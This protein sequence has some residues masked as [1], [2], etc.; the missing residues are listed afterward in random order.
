MEEWK[1]VLVEVEDHSDGHGIS[2]IAIDVAHVDHFDV[3][4]VLFPDLYLLFVVEE[5]FIVFYFFDEDGVGFWYVFCG[6]EDG[7]VLF[8]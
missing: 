1:E 3:F 8:A 5:I 2:G 7:F 4:A 6:F